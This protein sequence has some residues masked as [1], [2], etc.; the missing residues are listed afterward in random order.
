[1]NAVMA[2]YAPEAVFLPSRGPRAEGLGQIRARFEM[3]L[4]HTTSTLT[5][6]SQHSEISGNLGYDSGTFDETVTPME[7]GTT[8][9]H[10]MGNYL[11]LYRCDADGGC[12]ILEQTLTESVAM[13]P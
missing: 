2:L 7:G 12:K 13:R 11:F 5:L 10:F 4:P 3:V 8:V 6:Q 1:M 9:L